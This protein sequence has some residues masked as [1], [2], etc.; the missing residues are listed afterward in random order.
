MSKS[1]STSSF[2]LGRIRP[3]SL[4]SVVKVNAWSYFLLCLLIASLANYLDSSLM[5]LL[6]C[7]LKSD[8]GFSV[9]KSDI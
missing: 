3:G 6:R 8:L 9:S 1:S 7:L 4:L 5:S 2:K